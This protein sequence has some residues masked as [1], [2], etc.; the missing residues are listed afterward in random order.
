M[1]PHS[2]VAPVVI[3]LLFVTGCGGGG[4]SSTGPTTGPMTATI[5]GASWV[6]T[7]SVEAR[8]THSGAAGIISLAG[9]NNNGLGLGVAFPDSGVQSYTLGGFHPSNATILQGASAWVAN[10]TGGSGTVTV[11]ALDATHVAGTFAFNAVPTPGTSASG[12][13]HVTNGHFDIPF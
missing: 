13:K 4:G 2:I 9:S 8:R 1:R 12:T 6:A 3:S 7:L 10:V 11:T 5:D